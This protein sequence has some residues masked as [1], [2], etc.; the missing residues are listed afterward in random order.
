MRHRAA[1]GGLLALVG[2]VAA[3]FGG[4]DVATSVTYRLEPLAGRQITDQDIDRVCRVLSRRLT[5]AGL[6]D[7]AITSRGPLERTEI[8]VTFKA[9][10]DREAVL[11][12]LERPGTI[13]FRIVAPAED[14]RKWRQISE[15]LDGPLVA[16]KRFAWVPYAAD[17]PECLVVTPERP[18]AAH[19]EKLLA[20]GLPD[21]DVVV[22]SLRGD[23]ERVRRDE[24]FTGDQLQRVEVH[25]QSTQVLVYFAFR[26]DRKTSFGE[27]TER[28]V[29]ELLAIILDGKVE[30]A[31]VIRSRL[32][33][34]G[35]I[36]G[37]GATGFTEREARELASV[38]EAGAL[39]VRLVR[40]EAPEKK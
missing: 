15:E 31:P 28:H 3:A 17:R 30:S 19:I 39:P 14:T 20:S 26:E 24:V 4:E 8:S 36:E 10:P 2:V 5:G 27:F 6:G 29:K 33:G 13:E 37:G 7:Q 1:L 11:R 12:M 32:P 9:S 40:V 38:L 16:P 34:E 25:R 35:I 22:E 18:I 21:D 23:L